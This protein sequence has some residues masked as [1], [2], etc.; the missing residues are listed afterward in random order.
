MRALVEVRR[1]L[2][3]L[4][5]VGFIGFCGGCH[6][7]GVEPKPP[8]DYP[9]Y[10]YE[11]YHNDGNWYFRYYPSTSQLDSVWLPYSDAPVISADG[12]RMYVRDRTQGGV[13]IVELD[14]FKTVGKLAYQ[15]PVA[16]SP[17][18]QYVAMYDSGIS[19]LN[20]TDF[21]VVV[22]DSL[23]RTGS[24][25]SNSRR[26]YGVSTNGV[27]RV[28]IAVNTISVSTFQ[29]PWGLVRDVES[30]PDETKLYLYMMAHQFLHVFGVYDIVGDS[31][32]VADSVFP[33]YGE[34]QMSSDGRRVFYTNAGT[35][36]GPTPGLPL[37][38]VY[39]VE[40]NAIRKQIST[41]GILPEPY[42]QGVSLGELC[43]TPDGR[44]L[45]ALGA[46][47]PFVFT[48]DMLRLSISGYLQTQY[49]IQQGLACQNGR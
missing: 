13:A 45:V 33:G 9:V 18:G 1:A 25:S 44:W 27:R 17:D 31:L 20:T 34:L 42:R 47:V 2:L 6:D 19:I 3:S 41:V 22:N 7:K 35:M 26:F 40:S 11:A 8:K 21:S 46:Q 30:S 29:I 39:D 14:S 32:I 4:G 5:A 23:S 37:I 10:Y 49:G 38:N 48:V 15:A 12:S 36:A 24:F 43:V 28:N 16:V